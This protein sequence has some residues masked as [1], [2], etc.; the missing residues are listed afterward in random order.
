MD[1]SSIW[2]RPHFLTPTVHDIGNVLYQLSINLV[3]FLLGSKM[4]KSSQDT[5]SS[6]KGS[7]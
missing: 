6:S 2:M 7:A 1:Q 4:S 5:T 3:I